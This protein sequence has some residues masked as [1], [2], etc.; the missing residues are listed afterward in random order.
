MSAKCWRNQRKHF[1]ANENWS[2][3]QKIKAKIKIN[4]N[5]LKTDKKD[6]SDGVI[7][8]FKRFTQ[9]KCDSNGVFKP[10]YLNIFIATIF[11]KGFK[12]MD[13]LQYSLRRIGKFNLFFST[14][15]TIVT[16]IR[17]FKSFKFTHVWT[18]FSVK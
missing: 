16:S 6:E 15:V 11:A 1:K 2:H 3:Q 9:I 5:E 18:D 17:F 7:W 8:K 10:S 14:Q 4:I 12:Q 13:N